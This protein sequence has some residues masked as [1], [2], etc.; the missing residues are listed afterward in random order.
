MVGFNRTD[1][2]YRN[3]EEANYII[4]EGNK[5]NR[6]CYANIPFRKMIRKGVIHEWE[7]S[8]EEL[9]AELMPVQGK[10][11]LERLKKRIYKDGEVQWTEGR[12]ILITFEGDSLPT[13][14]LIGYGHVWL[15]VEPFMES[16]KQCF[17]CYRYEHSQQI[18]RSSVSNCRRCG[19]ER[20][21][22]C[23]KQPHCTKCA[24]S[25]PSMA[26]ECPIYQK[27]INI[28]KVMAYQNWPYNTGKTYIENKY[29]SENME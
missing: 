17:K 12:A 29:R 16:V 28:K 14:V 3:K 5:E 15:R 1:I 24:G 9:E 4:M 23:Q 25:H 22:E 8:V 26:R 11:K 7:D 6:K 2:I 27:E 21:E 19:E 10:F 20:H 13:R 18:C